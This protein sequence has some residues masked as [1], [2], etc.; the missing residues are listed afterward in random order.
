M[1]KSEWPEW[2]QKLSIRLV[3]EKPWEHVARILRAFHG[4]ST[5][6]D[7]ERLF[8]L[9][10][11]NEPDRQH[12]IDVASAPTNCGTSARCVY[13]LAG[14]EEK[15]ITC[16]YPGQVIIGWL[17]EVGRETDAQIDLKKYPDAWQNIDA[18]DMLLYHG[19]G[20]DW[21]VEIAMDKPDP[22]TGM[23]EHGGGGKA[24]NGIAIATSDIRSNRGR[25][26]VCFIRADRLLPVD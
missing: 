19:G 9:F 5:K 15:L 24:N 3:G 10:M 6:V 14:S 7:P 13:A 1:N 21:H 2:M 26:L 11:V 12:A 22:E 4:C 20:N 16:P 23:C 8:A 18:G 25:P 17:L